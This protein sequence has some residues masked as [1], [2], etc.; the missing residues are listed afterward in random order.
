MNSDQDVARRI[1]DAYARRDAA[2]KRKLYG[3]SQPD[4][5][6]MQYRFRSAVARALI[7]AGFAELRGRDCLDVG[8]GTGAWLRT[9][10]EWGADAERL[11]GI[12]LLADR[13]ATA[14]VLAPQVDVRESEGSIPFEAN[15]MD[16]VSAYTVFSSIPVESAR[17]GLAAE[18][19]RVLR[20]N[21]LLLIYDFRIS[22]PRNPDT[23]GIGAREIRHLFPAFEH[24][25]RSLT[26]AP[27]LQRPLARMSPLLAHIAEAMLPF[28]RTHA[29]HVLRA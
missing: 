16:I 8:C 22:D 26:L 21:G 20:K 19:S 6:F 18:M 7:D 5:L 1:R 15:T 27:P 29:L 12:D 25:E 3:W 28:L 4:V 13:V 9:L 10:M 11:H 14:R 17:R 23:V 2:G 24:R